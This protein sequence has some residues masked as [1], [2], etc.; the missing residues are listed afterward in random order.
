[1]GCTGP[2]KLEKLLCERYCIAFGGWIYSLS[3]A[4]RGEKVK[5]ESVLPDYVRGAGSFFC[6]R[7]F[8]G[9]NWFLR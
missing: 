4:F 1:M 8:V 5:R 7:F 9:D 2:V 3:G 6:R